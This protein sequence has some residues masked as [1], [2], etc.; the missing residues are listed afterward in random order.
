MRAFAHAPQRRAVSAASPAPAQ[1]R[2]PARA[3][4]P[5]PQAHH[6][7]ADH[8]IPESPPAEHG[9]LFP[10]SAADA[11]RPSGHDFSRITIH[12]PAPLTIQSKL[13]VNAPG[14]VH[15]AEAER[16]SLDVM[17][18]P[19]VQLQRAC[20]CGG[21]CP[22]CRARAD[23][24]QARRVQAGAPA[25]I[26]APPIVHEVLAGPGR[27]LEPSVRDFMEPRLG[28]DFS[29]VRVHTDEKAA[30]SARAVDALAY[31]AGRNLVF[32][33]GRYEP[34]T[35]AGRQLLAHE[36][37]HT[38]QQ[39][40]VNP[41][42]AGAGAAAAPTTQT[43]GPAVQ[44]AM[45]FEI[46]TRNRVFRALGTKRSLLPRKF[47]PDVVPK[48]QDFLHKGTRGKAPTATE[49]GTAI[50]LQSEA[51]GF[52]EFETPS[53]HRDWCEIKERIQE[54]VDMVDTINKSKAV[55]TT[56]GV[57]TVEFPFDTKHLAVTKSFPKGLKSGEKLE[58]EI[59]D[60]AWNAKI[61][62]SESFELPQFESYL[63]EH[64]PGWFT[65]ITG[66]AKK[67]VDAANTAKLPD[68]DLVNLRSLLQII[69]ETLTAVRQWNPTSHTSLAKEQISLM[70]RTNLS[71][72]YSTLLS[73]DEQDLFKAIVKSEAVLNEFGAKREDLVFKLGYKGLKS[74][75][76]TI[77]DWLVSIHAQKRDLLSSIGGDNR[78]MGRFDVDTTA[79]KKDTNL[80]KFEARGTAGH[81]Q[82]RP[83]V[84]Q[85]GPYGI[86]LLGGWVQFAEEVFKA[87]ATNRART[88]KTALKYDP[89]KCP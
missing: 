13:V 2:G 29:R 89:G 40:A 78:A 72:I 44:R 10:D 24:L 11:F 8:A 88:G 31:T 41:L 30:E 35:P 59:K 51:H 32:D 86:V 19:A 4:S 28:H 34:G 81:Q 57:V 14:D 27:P 87:A 21:R 85:K 82:E 7:R 43:G 26:A 73:K 69:V 84:D 63:K 45:K 76:P 48:H 3:P 65:S 79:G 1:T 83:V 23:G 36:L 77:H 80:V 53:W 5:V 15:E 74:P 55:S 52:V 17:R 50:E 54:A 66:S 64:L 49:E 9:G 71:S 47:G 42:S 20:P 22:E 39:G 6:T 56:A 58:V 25:S 62:A 33:A 38:I 61:Q 75:G 46:Q 37:A 18:M 70:S 16:I 60:P 67:I 12:P 68:K